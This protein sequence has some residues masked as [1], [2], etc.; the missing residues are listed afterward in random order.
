MDLQISAIEFYS[1]LLTYRDPSDSVPS[2]TGATLLKRGKHRSSFSILFRVA[3]GPL[4]VFRLRL[5]RLVIF[6][7]GASR[8]LARA[9][10]S[11]LAWVAGRCCD[12]VVPCRLVSSPLRTVADHCRSSSSSPVSRSGRLAWPRVLTMNSLAAQVRGLIEGVTKKNFQA[13]VGELHKVRTHAC[14]CCC[15]CCYASCVR[16]LMWRSLYSWLLTRPCSRSLSRYART[17]RWAASS[18]R[19]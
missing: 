19:R 7:V 11:F 6:L 18:A 13:T 15:C 3:R 2:A 5:L 16:P 12:A 9:R 1:L 4:E 8:S 17:H 14:C 10:P